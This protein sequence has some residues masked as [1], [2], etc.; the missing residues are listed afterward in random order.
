[1]P[2]RSTGY[3][4]RLKHSGYPL[5]R[6]SLVVAWSVLWLGWM[7]GHGC[8]GESGGQTWENTVKAAVGE[9]QVSVYAT[10]GFEP[11]FE[12]FQK[13]FPDIKANAVIGRGNQLAQK[14]LAERRADKF[15]A[16]VYLGGIGTPYTVFYRGSLLVPIEPQ[17][18]L[19]DVVDKAK[20]FQGKFHFA[21]DDARYM[22]IFE[23][24]MRSDVAYNTQLVR[25]GDITSY[26]SFTDTKWKGKIVAIDPRETGVATSSSL[27]FFYHHPE[28]G[29]EYLRRLFGQMDLT[30][31]RDPRQMLDWLAVGRFALALF[32]TDA[33][34][35]MRQGLPVGR[36]APTVFK[37]GLYGRPQRGT[38]SV[39]TRAPHPDAAKVFVN[40][41]LSREGQT[42]FQKTFAEDYSLSLRQDVTQENVPAAFRFGKGTKFFPAYR[43]E[44]IDTKPA[45]KVIEAAMRSAKTSEAR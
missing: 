42:V 31:S 12:A 1:M 15:L 17:F 43:P 29:P 26:W 18:I 19:S 30:Y 24:A 38:V 2:G 27:S 21:D 22:F 3:N 40:W 4:A 25:T 10:S 7:L 36:F 32:A 9:G 14:L 13:R 44:Y 8:A 39:F 34:I 5:L 23:M 11:V 16:D 45:L 41:L 28:L 6:H 35:A 37:E 20:W 33:D